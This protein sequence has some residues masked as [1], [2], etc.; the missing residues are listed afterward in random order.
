MV[1]ADFVPAAQGQGVQM[2]FGDVL[3]DHHRQLAQVQ[4]VHFRYLGEIGVVFQVLDLGG[5]GRI[6][7]LHQQDEKELI[8]PEGRA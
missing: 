8:G 7:V 2:V 5:Y 1:R 4:H 3:I 6:V